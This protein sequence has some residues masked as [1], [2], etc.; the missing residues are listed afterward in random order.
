MKIIINTI[1][2]I[3]L[4]RK[5]PWVFK[6]LEATFKFVELTHKEQRPMVTKIVLVNMKDGT[7]YKDFVSL[8]A[9]IGEA[10]PIDRCSHLKSQNEELKRLVKKAIE[11][12]ISVEDRQLMEL[13]LKHF[14]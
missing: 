12:N 10:N 2:I 1:K 8:W 3:Q 14:N 11:G 9:G 13:T 5:S 6:A 4:M 7:H